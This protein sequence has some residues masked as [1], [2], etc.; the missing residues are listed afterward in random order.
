[1]AL[2]LQSLFTHDVPFEPL[3]LRSPK[4]TGCRSWPSL[5]H[6]VNLTWA[7]STGSTQA[8]GS[9][10]RDGTSG[11]RAWAGF[12]NFD[13]RWRRGCSG[14]CGRAQL[15]IN[16]RYIDPNRLSRDRNSTQSVGN[17]ALAQKLTG[18]PKICGDSLPVNLRQTRSFV[19]LHH[20]NYHPPY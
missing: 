12:R 17:W 13:T 3:S 6:S 19:L 9:G 16:A 7:I 20:L 18:R 4:K 14:C 10:L 1:M 11:R 8:S 15:V 2:N 5:V